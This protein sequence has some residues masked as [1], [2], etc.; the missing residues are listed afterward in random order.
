MEKMQ[1]VQ[2]AYAELGE[3]EYVENT[4]TYDA[5]RAVYDVVLRRAQAR[6]HWTWARV[7]GR[8]LEELDGEAAEDGGGVSERRR[9]SRYFM[10]PADCLSVYGLEDADGRAVRHWEIGVDPVSMER[11]VVAEGAE[12]EVYMTYTS[13][14]V[15]RGGS[16]PDEAAEFCE[17]V[18]LML[19]GKLARAVESNYE[20]AGDLEQRAELAMQRA[21]V[22]DARQ[23]ASGKQD[24]LRGVL[25]RDILHV[26]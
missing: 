6:F 12:G 11:C 2:L 9:G 19:A 7:S 26:R 14:L 8:R 10:V 1:V 16:V 4:A 25:R 3:R 17:A 15:A 24:P 13:D 18:V 5:V 22:K 23:W 21:M 20:L